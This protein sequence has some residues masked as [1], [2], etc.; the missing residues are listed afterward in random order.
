MPTTSKAW[1]APPFQ[2][3]LSRR[4]ARALPVLALA[5]LVALAFV[6]VGAQVVRLAL[7]GASGGVRASF[8]EPLV[9]SY[10]RPDLVDRRGRLIASDLSTHSL[11]ADPV[12]VIDPDETSEAIASVLGDINRAELRSALADRSR[13]FIWIRRHLG[14]ADAQRVH[15]LGLPGLSFR[16]EPRRFYPQGRMAGH[17]I[18]SVNVDNRGMAGIERYIDETQGLESGFSPDF[19]RLPVMLTLDIGAQHAL[20]EELS[21]A[22]AQFGA[23]GAAGVI[24]DAASGAVL[25]GASLP[26]VD[27]AR[28][29]ESLLA[30]RIDRLN[31]A[32][33]EL[34]SVMKLFTVAMALEQGIATPSSVLDVRVP[35]QV[36]RWTIRDLVPSGRPLTVREVLAGNGNSWRAPG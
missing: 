11:Y 3:D 33:F 24:L 18:G 30:D 2:P 10:A 16:T 15:D 1:P 20:E 12:A 19:T 8:A 7:V 27:S 25:A 22:I 36:G 6:L 32:T 17:L 13:R 28:P 31:V 34:G 23:S 35:L 5:V 14:P 9:R 21:L 29:T 4:Q 26:D